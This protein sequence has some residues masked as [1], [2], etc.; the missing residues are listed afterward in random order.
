MEAARELRRLSSATLGHP[1]VLDIR[2]RLH[3]ARGQWDSALDVAKLVTT[4][5]PERPSGW[6]HQS[7]CLHEMKRT[8]EAMQLLLPV[9]DQFPEEGIIAYN[10]ACY[11]CQL[12]DLAG[13]KIW[14]QRASKSKGKMPLKEMA[15]QDPDL[16]PLME[17]IRQM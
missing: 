2:W 14:L 7:Y 10:L 6:I 5:A 4:V 16:A 1:D 17:F 11:A 3:A 15:E 9:A 8:A 12:G 13:A